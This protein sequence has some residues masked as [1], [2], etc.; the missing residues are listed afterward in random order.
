VVKLVDRWSVPH[1]MEVGGDACREAAVL[2]RLGEKEGCRP[3]MD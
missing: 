1:G 3:R 2:S